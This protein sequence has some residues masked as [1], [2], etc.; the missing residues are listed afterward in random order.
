[1]DTHGDGLV[2]LVVRHAGK[3]NLRNAGVFRDVAQSLLAI[4]LN[5]ID[6]RVPKSIRQIGPRAL[7]F[8]R[9]P[10]D[11]HGRKDLFDPRF[12][13]VASERG[14]G[15]HQFFVAFAQ[16]GIENRGG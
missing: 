8:E 4:R 1:M 7:P 10:S 2:P 9:T 6:L 13:V 3:V 15:S 5:P 14:I 16:F 12:D 11:L